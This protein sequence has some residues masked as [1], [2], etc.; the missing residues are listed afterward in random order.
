MCLLV[1]TFAGL[2]HQDL[3]SNN[4]TFGWQSSATPLSE[5]EAVDLIK[6]TFASAGER[7]IYTVSFVLFLLPK[8]RHICDSDATGILHVATMSTEYPL[9]HCAGVCQSLSGLRLI[10]F[11]LLV[12]H[13]WLSTST[14][15]APSL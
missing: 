1:I 4:S 8:R 7:D 5:A 3:L 2:N 10:G 11:L 15:V 9:L 14:L 12:G 13:P 6:D